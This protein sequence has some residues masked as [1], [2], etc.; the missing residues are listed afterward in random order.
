MIEQLVYIG[1]M[2]IGGLIFFLGLILFIWSRK[3]IDIEMEGSEIT[4]L[5]K[6]K[7]DFDLSR[8]SVIMM[9]VGVYIWR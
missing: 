4:D 6:I 1:K 3:I 8:N 2:T 7:L 9:A 5:D